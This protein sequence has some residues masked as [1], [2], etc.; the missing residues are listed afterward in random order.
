MNVHIRSE[1]ENDINAISKLTQLAFSGME[2]SSNTEHLIVNELRRQ[3]ALSISLVAEHGG[4][5]LGHVAVSP[6]SI[7][8]RAVAWFGLGPISVLPEYQKQGIGSQLM[9]QALQILKDQDAAGCVL[10]GDPNYYYRFGFRQAGDLV[11]PHAPSEYFQSICFIN[12][13]A[14][15]DAGAGIGG[16][17]AYHPAFLVEA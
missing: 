3:D 5:I 16:E 15:L 11:Y 8:S 12:T 14:S 4:R 1:N 2:H 9:H 17:V 10:L 13:D 7:S 6:V